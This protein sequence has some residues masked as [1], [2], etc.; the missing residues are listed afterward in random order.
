ME[1]SRLERG[2]EEV[3]EEVREEKRREEKRRLI[4]EEVVVLGVGRDELELGRS[5]RGERER[6]R[7]G[8]WLLVRTRTVES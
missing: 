2:Y 5:E 8:W 4:E 6:R 1:E 7:K 3:L